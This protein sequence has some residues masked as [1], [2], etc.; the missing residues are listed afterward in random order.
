MILTA[1]VKQRS[2]AIKKVNAHPSPEGHFYHPTSSWPF[3]S[4]MESSIYDRCS[5]ISNYPKRHCSARLRVKG[6]Q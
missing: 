2:Y 5:T 1:F 4:K 6:S 3:L